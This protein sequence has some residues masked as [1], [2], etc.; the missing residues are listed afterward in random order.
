[1]NPNN[2][3]T[4]TPAEQFALRDVLVG[5]LQVYNSIKRNWK[6]L[7]GFIFAG[8][9]GGL[10]FDLVTK[11]RPVYTASIVFNMGGV[12]PQQGGFGDI[13]S[14]LGRGGGGAAPDAG[15]F[16]GENFYSYALSRPVIEKALMKT[17]VVNNEKLLLANFYKD[18]SDFNEEFEGSP[19]L[20]NVRFTPSKPISKMNYYESIVLDQMYGRIKGQTLL[21]IAG[22]KVTFSQLTVGIENEALARIWAETLIKTIEEVHDS[23]QTQK[24]RETLIILK[25]RADSLFRILNRTETRMAAIQTVDQYAVMAESKMAETQLARKS[26][27]VSTMYFEAIRSYENLRVSLIKETPLFTIIEPV[28]LPLVSKQAKGNGLPI[29]SFL[30]VLLGL[31]AIYVKSLYQ[32]I[33]KLEIDL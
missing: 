32:Q 1:M 17:V 7:L 15:L 14:L 12:A 5:V 23:I 18:S 25:N 29:G 19:E 10:I 20:L 3:N 6:L 31:I 2:Q 24:S 16:V 30:G 27:F 28:H 13:S 26:G 22:K 33:K 9:L 21:D 8:I 11:E 4:N